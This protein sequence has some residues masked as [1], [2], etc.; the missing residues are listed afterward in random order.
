MLA[1]GQST[2]AIA[3]LY[4]K[5]GDRP[6]DIAGDVTILNTGVNDSD[7][8]VSCKVLRPHSGAIQSN[9]TFRFHPGLYLG[10]TNALDKGKV[11]FVC[12]ME[13]IENDPIHLPQLVFRLAPLDLTPIP[14]ESVKWVGAGKHPR[15]RVRQTMYQDLVSQY[16]LVGMSRESVLK[17]LGPPSRETPS[18]LIYMMGPEPNAFIAIDDVWLQLQVKDG[19][20]MSFRWING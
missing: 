11:Y 8:W 4:A 2:N 6:A 14:F 7:P 5:F 13:P 3:K 10:V 18:T 16:R 9:Q 20:I 15:N 12:I 17:L 1:H 19:M